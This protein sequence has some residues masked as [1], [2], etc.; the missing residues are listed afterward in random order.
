MENQN[1]ETA[2]SGPTPLP[3]TSVSSFNSI[4]EIKNNNKTSSVTVTNIDDPSHPLYQHRRIVS[5]F[6][7]GDIL[8]EGSYST[9]ILG[10]DK[11]TSKQYA[12][13]KL[14]KAHI[15]KN[16]K[17]KYVMIERDALVEL[18]ILVLLNY[19]G[20]L[21]ITEVYTTCLI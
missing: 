21:E 19:I 8:G 12:V 2:T 10:K 6:E 18:T 16:D 15:V 5:D 11:K 13:K 3:T 1:I 7:Y 9:V 14:D 17:V 4:N 20:L